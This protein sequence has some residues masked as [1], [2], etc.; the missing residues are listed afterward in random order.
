MKIYT[1]RHYVAAC[2]IYRYWKFYLLRR[3]EAIESEKLN[4]HD[5]KEPRFDKKPLSILL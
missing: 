2:I 3:D 5:N 4:K 1:T